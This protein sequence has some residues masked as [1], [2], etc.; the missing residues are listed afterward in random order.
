ME[1]AQIERAGDRGRRAVQPAAEPRCAGGH[2]IPHCEP[3]LVAGAD[4]ET[5]A[6][7]AADAVAAA[8]LQHH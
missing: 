3:Q 5:R 7:S 4:A 6:E 2:S 8:V 1:R